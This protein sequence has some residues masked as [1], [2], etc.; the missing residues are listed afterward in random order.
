MPIERALSR[1]IAA[2]AAVLAGLSAA[3]GAEAALRNAP[4]Q[5]PLGESA[6][7]GAVC[8]AVRDDDDP[9]AQVR[10][11]RAWQ[12]RCRGWD[13]A[14]GRLYAYSYKGAVQIQKDGLWA[15][16][17]A[18][19]AGCQAS[20][21]VELKGLN[22][23]GRSQCQATSVKVAYVAYSGQSGGRAVAAEGFV[24]IADVLETGLRVV[25]GQIAP[26]KATQSLVSA[27]AAA[28]AGGVSL[29]EASEAAEAAPENLRERG[30][31]R[32]LAWEFSD[33]V[34]D[35][36]A[37]AQN[38]NETNQARAE[39]YLNWALNTSNNGRFSQADSLFAQADK[40]AV[41]NRQLQG[42][43]LSYRALHLRNQRKFKESVAAA[44]EARQNLSSLQAASAQATAAGIQKTADGALEISPE[45]AIALR[46]P[47]SFTTGE[48]DP[49]ARIQIQIAQ[50]ELTEASSYEALG[51][52]APAREALERA[53]A[54]LG[55][56]A[57]ANVASF[58]KVQVEVELARQDQLGGR[59][60]EARQR[61]TEALLD[62]RQRQA[63]SPA[64]AY[65]TLELARA[66]AVNGEKA[67]AMQDFQVAIALFRETRGSL[68]ASADSAAAYFDLLLQQAS[69]DPGGAAGYA[70]QFLVAAES[71]GSQATADTVARLAARLNQTDPSSAGLIRALEDTRR[72]VRMKESAIALLQAQGQYTP[73]ARAANEDELK[74]LNTQMADLEQRV[75]SVDPHYGQLVSTDVSLKDLQGTLKPGELYLKVVLLGGGGYG[76]AVTSTSAKPY[77][78]ALS[79]AQ[80]AAAV[81]ALRRPFETEGRLPPYDVAGAHKLFEDLFGPVSD[82][83][84]AAKHIIYEPDDAILSLPIATL[85]TDQASVDLIA[86]RRA[87]IRA[88]GEGVLSYKGVRWLGRSARSSL[89]VSAASFVQAR[90]APPSPAPK[91][92]IGFGDSVAP[93]ADD[94][95]AFAS[96]VAYAGTGS[97]DVDL[98]GATRQALLQLKPLKEARQELQTVESAVGGS[99]ALVTGADFSDGAIAKRTDLDQYRVVYF[100]TH[101]LLP[102]P[103]SC[104]PEPALL[105]SVGADGMSDGLLDVSKIIGLKLDADL[106]VLSACDTGGSTLAGEQD[107]GGLGG[108]GAALGGLTRAFIYAGARSLLVS[109]WKIDSTATVRLMSSMFQSGQTTQDGGLQA[110]S[111]S[112]MDSDDQ[113]SHPYYWAAFTVVGDGERTLPH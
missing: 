77:R 112:L 90:K 18:G 80:G 85:V 67:R 42:Q 16:A 100:A 21:P 29:V 95:R 41:G 103:G 9:A 68:G 36:R 78:I 61:L 73:A 89:V 38:V 31:S 65:L 64:E 94:P 19:R 30:Y 111:L 69:V 110:A 62:L 6:Q 17:L 57:V 71:L 75:A 54:R 32:N 109:H 27:S 45:L 93:S 14:L 7:S 20:A 82:E 99:G 47:R 24:Q 1:W 108:A 58:L 40:L 104:L 113:Y 22:G 72:Q 12:V 8:Q 96:V 46:P 11:G 63:G 59:N 81:E 106:V 34:T 10:G 44:E 55:A 92:F 102:E 53:Q 107:A 83:L 66:E 2:G 98:C 5:F 13:N 84:A 15:K 79:E 52:A 4:D 26:P 28:G 60:Q 74:S 105:T 48:L 33:A 56:P 70:S 91:S 76:L 35:F 101:G 51:Q 39:A 88:K 87:A 86:S 50:T 3:G 43:A 25:G 23:V 49:A 37:L 97:A